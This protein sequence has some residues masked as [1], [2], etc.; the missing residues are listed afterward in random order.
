[1]LGAR[2]IVPREGHTTDF[3][4][5]HSQPGSM[6]RS[7]ILE[8]EQVVFRNKYVYTYTCMHAITMKKRLNLKASGER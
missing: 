2:E 6:L 4:V 8:I 5:S 7:H 1:M 3:P